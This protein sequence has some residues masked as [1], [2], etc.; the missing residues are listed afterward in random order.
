M[1]S[2]DNG[3]L[4]PL[5]KKFDWQQQICLECSERS[6][7]NQ[8]GVCTE[9]NP[10]CKTYNQLACLSCYPGYTLSN[11][12]CITQSTQPTDPG[13]ARYDWGSKV[14][15]QCSY[16]FYFNSQ[17]ICTKISDLCNTF[18]SLTGACLS[19]YQG[20]ALNGTICAVSQNND[21]NQQQSPDLNCQSYDAK[22]KTCLACSYRFVLDKNGKCIKVNDQCQTW[23]NSGLCT[24]CYQGYNLSSGVCTQSSTDSNCAKYDSTLKRCIQCATRYFL[25]SSSLCQSVSD[26]CQTF[27]NRTGY[28]TSCYQGY[29]LQNGQCLLQAEGCVNYNTQTGQCQGCSNEYCLNQNFTCARKPANCQTCAFQGGCSQCNPGYN[30]AGGV[31][32]QQNGNNGTSR[33]KT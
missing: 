8:Q 25:N 1:A 19:C 24:S 21:N 12:Q 31:C 26:Q 29:L 5:C 22:T 14:C 9:V 28:C 17:N 3:N 18:D 23:D 20:Y 32:V 33:C 10:L 16:R 2:G 4:D 15:L 11:G 27:D 7:K 6:F 13:C 30:L